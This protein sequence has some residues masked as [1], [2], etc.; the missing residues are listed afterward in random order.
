MTASFIYG[1][2]PKAFHLHVSFD[3]AVHITI[4]N[5]ERKLMVGTFSA[6]KNHQQQS[7]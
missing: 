1:F 4:T 6:F 2:C 3:W 7:F 5:V